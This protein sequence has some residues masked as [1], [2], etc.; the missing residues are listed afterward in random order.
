M[1][2]S[3]STE[4]TSLENL[5]TDRLRLL[6][7]IL[8]AVCVVVLFLSVFGLGLLQIKA[9][10]RTLESWLEVNQARIEEAMYLE[11]IPPVEFRAREIEEKCVWTSR[12][13]VTVFDASG[14]RVV[15]ESTALP[16]PGVREGARGVRIVRALVYAHAP[17]GT[18]EA[19]SELTLLGALL[20]F[21]PAALISFGLYLWTRTLLSSFLNQLRGRILNPL[22]TLQRGMEQAQLRGEA[23]GG[24]FPEEAVREVKELASGYSSL[25]KRLRETSEREVRH[26][27]LLSQVELARQVAHDIRSPLAAF[28]AVLTEV[29][30][31][32]ES[33]RALLRSAIQRIHSIAN[34]MLERGRSVER[35]V[36]AWVALLTEQVVE[37]KRLQHPQVQITNGFSPFPP[38]AVLCGLSD[39]KR[40][41]SNVLENAIQASGQDPRIE[42]RVERTDSRLRLQIQDH[43]RGIPPEVLERVGER[44]FSFGKDSGSGLGISFVRERVALW[45]GELKIASQ[46]GKGTTVTLELPLVLPS[47]WMCSGIDVQGVHSVT[48]LD[49]DPEV[50]ERWKRRAPQL[51]WIGFG[52][53]PATPPHEAGLFLVD[54]EFRG[55]DL[56]GI[57]WIEKHALQGTCILVTHRWE[58]LQEECARRGIRLLPKGLIER[59]PLKF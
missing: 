13:S 33:A 55:G 39:W 32:E 11:N 10:L 19:K 14:A 6:L 31:M 41:L 38:A 16:S 52:V 58:E 42:I 24:A 27:Q 8:L 54:D 4:S 56:R 49:D 34:Q 43:G 45:G 40:A 47:P 50:L 1:T 30:G 36:A 17:V 46:V 48:V 9:N 37:E 2:S 21:L 23:M 18:I 35:P 29:D 57:D 5:V 7:R 51:S 15:G 28:Q 3:R 25:L 59:V 22:L 12:C 53:L 44:G 20:V 26:A